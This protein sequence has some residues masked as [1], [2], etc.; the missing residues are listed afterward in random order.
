[1]ILPWHCPLGQEKADAAVHK[2]P[3]LKSKP[4]FSLSQDMCTFCSTL[5]G[6]M[7]LKQYRK[8]DHWNWHHLDKGPQPLGRRWVPPIRPGVASEIKGTMNV[9]HLNH[10]E[11]TPSPGSVEKLSPM[12]LV[13]GAKKVG[14]HWSRPFYLNSVDNNPKERGPGTQDSKKIWVELLRSK[15][16]GGERDQDHAQ[17]LPVRN[18]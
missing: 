11:T 7:V 13:P 16:V 4:L 18:H 2:P 9:M 17:N 14:D 15:H 12:K 10:P 3:R 8:T 6:H 5:I 1:M